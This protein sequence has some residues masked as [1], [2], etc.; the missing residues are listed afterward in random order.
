[1]RTV[2]LTA[3]GLALAAA[4]SAQ[5]P[6]PEAETAPPAGVAAMEDPGPG[7]SSDNL[8]EMV[9]DELQG[10]DTSYR[11]DPRGRRDPF[12]SLLQYIT[13]GPDNCPQ[14]TAGCLLWDE[15]TL[16]GIWKVKGE[17]VSQI[18]A[19]NGDVYWVR[20]GENLYDGQVTRIGIDCIYFKQ[21]V[22]DPTKI[23][24]FRD[25]EKCVKSDETK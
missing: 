10:A 22:N 9:K 15:I 2:L 3:L 24:P 14:G 16:K 8:E 21:K 6:V 13:K 17:F 23:N 5:A 4:L 25:V 19:K 11:Y 7:L 20:E 18:L 1:M 12:R